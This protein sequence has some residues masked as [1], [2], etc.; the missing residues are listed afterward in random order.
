MSR[1]TAATSL[2]LKRLAV[3]APAHKAED[4]EKNH[5]ILDPEKWRCCSCLAY[6]RSDNQYHRY[7]YDDHS[8]QAKPK[9]FAVLLV[10]SIKF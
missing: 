4:G 7:C 6:Q 2:L 1:G 5:R 10:I 9:R 8:R 3:C